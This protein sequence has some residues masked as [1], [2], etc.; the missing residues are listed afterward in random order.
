MIHAC[1]VVLAL[2]RLRVIEGCVVT[3]VPLEREHTDFADSCSFVVVDPEPDNW[4]RRIQA[5][6]NEIR[7][8]DPEPETLDSQNPRVQRKLGTSG[9]AC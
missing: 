4:A 7:A 6:C 8:I 2:L 5:Y 9:F 1:E 3:I